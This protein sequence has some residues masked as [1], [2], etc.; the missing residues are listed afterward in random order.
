MAKRLM[1]ALRIAKLAVADFFADDMPTYAAA[2]SYRVLFSLFPF[3][4]FLTA[5]LGFLGMPQLF[6][7]LREQAAYVLPPEGMNLVNTVLSELQTP[8]GGLMSFAVAIALWSASAAVVETMNALNVAYDVRER[9][10]AWKRTLVSIL[11]TLAL[12]IMLG[13]AAGLMLTGPALLGWVAQFVGLNDV[14]IAIWTWIRWPVAAFLLMVAAALVYYAAPN[15]QQSFRLISPGAVIAVSVWILASLG[16]AFYV[17]TFADY[18][19]TYGSMGAVIILLLYF[20]LS[21]AVFLFGAEV[22]AVVARGR[23][24]VIEGGERTDLQ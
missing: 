22:N 1:G 6:D 19:K 14:F 23:G 3:L 16:F 8:Q 2:L 21:A 15:L 5:L 10:P 9:R 11:Y 24:E 17:Q 13:L 4:I 7:W 18:N 20:F 12:A